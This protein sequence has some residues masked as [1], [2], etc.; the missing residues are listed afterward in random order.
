MLPLVAARRRDTIG[1]QAL[2]DLAGRAASSELFEDAQ[3]DS[4]FFWIDDQ[5]PLV[6]EVGLVAIGLAA[7]RHAASH[8]A[9]EAA[10]DLAGIV[11]AEQLTHQTTQ[12]NGDR[13]RHTFVDRDDLHALGGQFLVDIGEVRHVAGQAVE[14]LDENDI[15]LAFGSGG[16]ELEQPATPNDRGAGLGCVGV[17]CDDREAVV[18]RIAC[19][20]GFLIS[21]G[22]FVLQVRAEPAVQYRPLHQLPSWMPNG[23]STPGLA[24]SH[25]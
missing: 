6:G 5:P 16:E 23:R 12:A 19:Q 3:D 25:G 24:R 4:R 2:T 22:L 18:R 15:E 8:L 20:N 14:L 21:D 10:A 1:V 7:G 17:F 11:L 9:L 13:G